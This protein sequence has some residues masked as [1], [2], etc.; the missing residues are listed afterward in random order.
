M[1]RAM[2]MGT[3]AILM[4]ATAFGQEVDDPRLPDPAIT[5]FQNPAPGE[6]SFDFKLKGYVFGLRMIK[7][8]FSGRIGEN[9]YTAFADIY[10][11]GLGALLKKLRIWAVTEGRYD[12]TQLYPFT[13]TQQNMD[14]KSR[15]V[16]MAYDYET[17]RVGV[18]INPPIGSQ[19]VPPATPKERFDAKDT[20]S[21]IL[22]LMM[23]GQRLEGEICD[24]TVRVFDSKQHYGLRLER[25]GT[26]RVK[27]EGEK[28]DSIHCH[29]YYEP[30][31]GFDPEDLPE[32]EES[33]TPINA[34]FVKDE[35]A[36]LYVPARFTYKIS[37]FKAVIKLSDMRVERGAAPTP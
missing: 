22:T 17:R 33:S 11:S 16:D 10:T 2:I 21:A 5:Q 37:G 18:D 12:K 19:G 28:V 24:G 26:D 34:Y 25:V 20:V 9:D 14:K 23:Q 3:A 30:I 6:T 32:E 8:S 35:Q 27:Y 4:S 13:H 31:S 15:R 7:S 29:I 36:G 1:K